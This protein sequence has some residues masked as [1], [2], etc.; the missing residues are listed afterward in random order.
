MKTLFARK[1][2]E[3][4]RPIS[5]DLEFQ[6]QE[7]VVN[8]LK[9]ELSALSKEKTEVIHRINAH[10]QSRVQ[11]MADVYLNGGNSAERPFSTQIQAKLDDLSLR[12]NALHLAIGQAEKDM[13]AIVYKLSAATAKDQEAVVRRAAREVLAGMLAIQLAN[14]E[15]VGVMEAR[16]FAGYSEHFHPVGLSPWPFWGDPK[17]E[18]SVWRIILDRFLHAGHISASEKH[19]IENGYLQ[20]DIE[21]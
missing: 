19:R 21:G 16:R 5:E 14:N 9:L 15:I 11:V 20:I 18:W 6:K 3:G 10:S 1:P 13:T 8:G 12:I 7:A 17:D 2:Q 4:L